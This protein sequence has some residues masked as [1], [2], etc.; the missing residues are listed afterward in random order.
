[1]AILIYDAHWA[2][3]VICRY[4]FEVQYLKNIIIQLIF[5][6]LQKIQIVSE[7]VVKEIVS[8]RIKIIVTYK[9]AFFRTSL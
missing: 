8:Y 4:I 3:Y 1:M 7:C 6:G 5:V 9:S 2:G